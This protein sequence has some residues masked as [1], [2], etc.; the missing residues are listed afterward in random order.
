MGK[1]PKPGS[2]VAQATAKKP[3][4]GKSA[5]NAAAKN[6]AKAAEK[7]AAAGGKGKGKK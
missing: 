1:A 5:A 3:K 7:G 2:K 4:P 6:E